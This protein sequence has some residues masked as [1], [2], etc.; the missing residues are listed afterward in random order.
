MRLQ[1][2]KYLKKEH[3]LLHADM[4]N[5]KRFPSRAKII[6]SGLG[7]SNLLNIAGGLASQNNTVFV[8]G[9]AGFI[10]HRYEQLKFSCKHFGV[11]PCNSNRVK[12]CKIIICNAGKYGYDNLGIG[13]SLDDDEQIMKILDIPFYS[14][15]T[16]QE[17]K[18]ILNDI[19]QESSGVFYIQ[20]GRDE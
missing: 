2:S 3:Y 19:E 8:Y 7:E 17:F 4:W 10:I 13:H 5:I 18:K 9:V 1:L 6:N 16:V 15:D 20:L 11:K 14:P 12:P